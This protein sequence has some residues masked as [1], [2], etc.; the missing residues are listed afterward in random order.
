MLGGAHH[1]FLGRRG[2]CEMG[3]PEAL[4]EAVCVLHQGFSFLGKRLLHLQ[5]TAGLRPPG[6]AVGRGVFPPKFLSLIQ[7]SPFLPQLV[8]GPHYPSPLSTGMR[9]RLLLCISHQTCPGKHAEMGALGCCSRGIGMSEQ[10]AQRKEV[11]ASKPG[12]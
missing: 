10:L 12:P 4:L 5:S 2:V 8:A 7:E 3:R 1:L 11:G 6:S 9:H